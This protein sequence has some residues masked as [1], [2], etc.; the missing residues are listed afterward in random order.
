MGRGS[1]R[2]MQE[3]EFG[4][5]DL[6]FAVSLVSGTSA[7]TLQKY[8]SSPSGQAGVLRGYPGLRIQTMRW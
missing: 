1:D 8:L 2:E 4:R 3:L 5:A 6:K 7:H